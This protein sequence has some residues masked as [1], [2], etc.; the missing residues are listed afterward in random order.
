MLALD[1]QLFLVAITELAVDECLEAIVHDDRIFSFCI[2]P[3]IDAQVAS[4]DSQ[5]PAA[6]MFQL[7][8]NTISSPTKVIAFTGSKDKTVKIVDLL[9]GQVLK[10]MV[11]QDG[12]ECIVCNHLYAASGHSQGIIH[13]W[14]AEDARLGEHLR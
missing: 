4:N 13:L 11:A 9:T 12:V 10:V 5:F 3:P 2:R 6:L 7:P 1:H 14:S 8:G